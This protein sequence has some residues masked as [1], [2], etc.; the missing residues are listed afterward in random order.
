MSICFYNEDV[1]KPSINYSLLK[2]IIKNQILEGNL[3]L[4]VIN[5][6]FCS[7]DHLLTIN[8]EFLQHDYYTDVI[9]FDYTLKGVVS[10]DVFIS[11]DRVINNAESYRENVDSELVRVIM[12]G[13]LHLLGYNDKSPGEVVVM[14]GKESMLIDKYFKLK[15]SQSV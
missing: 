8:K 12:H 4:G 13:L 7:D 10:G 2:K 14:R 6:I 9:T 1:R 11:V 15:G 3:K 5:Y